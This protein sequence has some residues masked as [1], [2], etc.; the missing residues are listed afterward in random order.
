MTTTSRRSV[1]LP[2]SGKISPDLRFRSPGTIALSQTYRRIT[3][4]MRLRPEQAIPALTESQTLLQAAKQFAALVFDSA[5]ETDR[6]GVIDCGLWAQFRHAGLAMSP[7]PKEIGGA[8]LWEMGRYSDLC[9]I[10]RL[11]G[12]ADLSV[13]R[14][15]EGHVNAVSLVARYGDREQL[16]AL[17]ERIRR[18][19]LSGVWGANDANGLHLVGG[20][21]PVLQG[22]KILASGAGFVTDPV[23]T[24]QADDGQVMCLL[25][26]AMDE[27]I[28]LF[29]W[30]ALGMRST[31]TGTIDLSGVEVTPEH[32]LGVAGD[33]MRQ[34]LFSG[35]AWRFCAAHV[36]ATE[37]L[38]DLFRDHLVARSRG[39]DPYQLQRLA[40][41]IASAKT[42]RTWV[43]EAARRLSVEEAD[44]GNVVAFANLT[45]M[46]TERCALDVMETVQRGVGLTSFIRP[47]PIERISRDLATYLRQPVPD[48][49]MSDGAKE[50]LASKLSV[51]EF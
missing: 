26:L 19:G 3:Q 25:H 24:A 9:A 22:R 46:V 21:K 33:F 5:I 29:G 14:L 42:A 8:G 43:E 34:P 41:C 44:A 31:A 6:T 45:R 12:S 2:C 15:F 1:R 40:Q 28:D 17:S 50:F 10:L 51:G 48:L 35:G 16:R 23:V 36:G 7:F 30:N 39:E 20:H 49:A 47:H 38:V 11:L 4:L 18:G 37:R 13:A 27:K 32:M